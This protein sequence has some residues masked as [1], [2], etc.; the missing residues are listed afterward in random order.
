ML[1][2]NIKWETNGLDVQVPNEVELPD[3]LN[4]DEI[5]ACLTDGYGWLVES[6]SVPM[7]DNDV[8]YF[9]QYVNEVEGKVS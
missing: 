2:T 8:D 6:F 1:V 4:D 3:Y 7:T 9:G 5:A